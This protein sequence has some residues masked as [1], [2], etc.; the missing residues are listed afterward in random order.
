MSD[1]AILILIVMLAPVAPYMLR[2]WYE[3]WR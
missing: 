3:K 1:W 2:W